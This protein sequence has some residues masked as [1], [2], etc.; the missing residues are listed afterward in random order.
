[1]FNADHVE[2]GFAIIPVCARIGGSKEG[3]SD[4]AGLLDVNDLLA[5]A[6]A[7]MA[8]ASAERVEKEN[9]DRA[10]ELSRKNWHNVDRHDSGAKPLMPAVVPVWIDGEQGGK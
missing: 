7:E 2:W 1:M 3:V 10:T 6:D 9:L 5:H 4:D 8:D